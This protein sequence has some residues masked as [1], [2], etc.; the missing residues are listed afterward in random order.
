MTQKTCKFAKDVVVMDRLPR[1]GNLDLDLFNNSKEHVQIVMERE[2]VL[3]LSVMYVKVIGPLD[4]WT[5]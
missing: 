1:Q 5:R 3:D 4:Q 2:D